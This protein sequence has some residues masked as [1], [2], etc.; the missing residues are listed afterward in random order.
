M[1]AASHVTKNVGMVEE[2]EVPAVGDHSGAI[3]ER[4]V[5]GMRWRDE[6]VVGA[7][8]RQ[9]LWG[10]FSGEVRRTERDQAAYQTHLPGDDARIVPT[11]S[12]E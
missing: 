8:D 10:D 5:V 3:L 12:A 1:I 2:A 9:L 7:E 11:R 4:M 6:R